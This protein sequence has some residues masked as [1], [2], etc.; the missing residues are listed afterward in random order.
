MVKKITKKKIVVVIGAGLGGLTAALRLAKMGFKVSVFE[1]NAVT[2][3]KMNQKC[4]G[5]YRFDTGPS[6]LTMD[7]VFDEL[8]RFLG[9]KRQ[10]LLE[11][12]PLS[13]ICRYFFADNT[14][15]DAYQE[16]DLMQ[17][18]IRAMAPQDLDNYNRYLL[19]TKQMYHRTGEVFLFNPIHELRQLLHLKTLPQFINIARLDA[20]KT[21]HQR[22][23]YFF[24]DKRLVQIFDRYA[25][26]NG[27]DPYQAPAALNMIS[28]VEN[29]LGAY[30]ISGG[31]YHLVEIL[32]TL[33][34]E[35]EIDLHMASPVEKILVNNRCIS[36]LRVNGIDVPVD[37]VVCNRDV[38]TTYTDLISGFYKRRDKLKKLEPSLSALV[39]LWG[40]NRTHAHLKHHNIFFSDD[41]REEF[42]ELF[43]D[44]KPPTDPT[45]YV[46]ITSK[47]DKSHAPLGRENWFVLINMP[48]MTQ[49]Q[50]W[51]DYV[52]RL[53]KQVIKKLKQ[54]NIDIENNIE[55]E[56][57]FTPP[58]FRNLYG[59]NRGSIYGFASNN[60]F[61]AFMRPANRSRDIDKLYFVGG[62][63]HPGGGIPLVTLSSKIVSELIAYREG[64]KLGAA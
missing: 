4:I 16:A 64:I 8:F 19:Y 40:I 20:F 50:E 53:R 38:V 47:V 51:H 43:N 27:S 2:G 32:T 49:G 59:A 52:P 48:Y 55:A 15:F 17:K 9:K 11:F 58:M 30:Y 60:R 22:L 18:S 44:L 46:A 23:T 35:M 14:T 12:L 26:Y 62:S 61:A 24:S 3:G 39:F 10:D 6:V 42:I 1:K 37:Y 57:I 56:D 54:H 34:Q 33:C 5:K 21:M 13:P 28:Y 29:V 63:T 41:Y 31:M 25:T 45:I 7:F 36:G